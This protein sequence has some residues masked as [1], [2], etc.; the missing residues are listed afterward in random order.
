MFTEL[1]YNIDDEVEAALAIGI[2]NA[3]SNARIILTI[4][5]FF[6]MIFP[7][8]TGKKPDAF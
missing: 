7:P 5:D 6:F 8:F 3:M 2:T 4:V 1:T